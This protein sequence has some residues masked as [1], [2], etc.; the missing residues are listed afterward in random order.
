MHA[1][2]EIPIERQR[3][4]QRIDDGVTLDEKGRN[5]SIAAAGEK[6]LRSA[7]R[8]RAEPA[9]QARFCY[10]RTNRGMNES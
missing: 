9:V 5:W 10:P 2:G 1:D 4:L 3:H 6:P 8:V 7:S